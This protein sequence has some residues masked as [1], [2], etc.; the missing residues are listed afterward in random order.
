MRAGSLI[1]LCV[2]LV[3]LACDR[4]AEH[5]IHI[6]GRVHVY[7]IEIPPSA[8]PGA[9]FIAEL[10]PNDHPQV[11]ETKSGKGYRAAKV[12]LADGREGWVFSGEAVEIK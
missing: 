10:G 7:K 1:F 6:T 8:Y 2:G 3:L 4:D 11:L 9:D 12:R 5:T